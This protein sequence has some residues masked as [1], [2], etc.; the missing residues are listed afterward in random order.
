MPPPLPDHDQRLKVLLKEF[1]E[2]F[3][4]C[5]FPAWAARFDFGELTWLDK[6]M[7]LAPPQGE[8]RQLD[9]VARL[10]IR[11]G[12]PP[13]RAGRTDLLALVH[14]EVE[15]RESVQVFRPRMFEYYVQL[16]RESRLPVLP[17]GLFLRVG[18]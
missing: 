13:P 15:S 14:V 6:E 4:L 7:F 2:Q 9:L 10:R 8:K 18:L 5:F 16:R 12:A 11:P 17:I 1:F 3:F